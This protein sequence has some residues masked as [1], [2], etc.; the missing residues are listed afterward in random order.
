MIGLDAASCR[1]HARELFDPEPVDD[2]A[3]VEAARNECARCSIRLDCL[4]LALAQ[5]RLPGLWGGLTQ[6]ERARHLHA[7]RRDH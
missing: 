4:A 6:A 2:D 7:T 5:H 3:A 1:T